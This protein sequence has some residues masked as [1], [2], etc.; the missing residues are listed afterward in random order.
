[1][2]TSLLGTMKQFAGS[3]PISWGI[4]AVLVGISLSKI[5]PKE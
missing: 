4:L 3:K 5:K 2:M 1:M